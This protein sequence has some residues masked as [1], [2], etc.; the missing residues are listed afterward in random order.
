[1]FTT[2]SLCYKINMAS[3]DRLNS[4]FVYSNVTSVTYNVN[5]LTV[6]I[7]AFGMALQVMKHYFM[8][9]YMLYRE[10]MVRT[11]DH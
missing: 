9:I 5:S 3:Q 4:I 6:V 11:R 8:F 2:I 7:G 1:M 10:E